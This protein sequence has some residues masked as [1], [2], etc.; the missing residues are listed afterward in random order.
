MNTKSA[1]ALLVAAVLAGCASGPPGSTSYPAGPH[2]MVERGPQSASKPSPQAVP[3]PES[4][5]AAQPARVAEPARADLTRVF[6]YPER[7]QS[8]AQQDRDRYE[9]YNWAVHQTGFDPGRQP[10]AREQHAT[11]VPA[12]APGAT[13]VAGAVTGAVIGAAV[14]NPGNGGKGAIIGA[15]AGSML[16]AAAADSEAT[17][18]KRIEQ[19]VNRRAGNRTDARYEQ[20]AATYRR[21][22]SA[23]LEGRG[24]VVK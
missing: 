23:C 1:T 11:V 14:S 20:Q 15:I 18:A 17:Q 12:R 6:F 2:T 21:A 13:V 24:Y 3:Q 4:P 8:E 10:L 19:N 22:M 16:G 9:C 7:G 5:P